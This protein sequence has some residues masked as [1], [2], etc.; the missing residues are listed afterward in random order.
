MVEAAMEILVVS[1][2]IS[3]IFMEDFLAPDAFA[4]SA[5]ANVKNYCAARIRRTSGRICAVNS[6]ATL[7]LNSGVF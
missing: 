4:F 3:T 1:P 5:A 7:I 6:A 2:L